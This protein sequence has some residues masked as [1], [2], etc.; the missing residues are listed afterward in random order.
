MTPGGD[1]E[2]CVADSIMRLDDA[3]C[4]D[5]LLNLVIEVFG[6]KNGKQAKVTTAHNLR[7]P[8]VNNAGTWGRWAFIEITD[9]WD[10]HR[11]IGASL[12]NSSTPGAGA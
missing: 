9:P 10:A 3:H 4:K 11:T 7:V 8:S 12:D 5:D 1:Y 6:H 2:N